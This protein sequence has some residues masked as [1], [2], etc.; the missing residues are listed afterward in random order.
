MSAET[1]KGMTNW[2]VIVLAAGKG[3]RMKSKRPKVLH[4]LCG[5]PMTAHVI[6]AAK[7]A[8]VSRIVV[9]VGTGAEEVRAALGTGYAYAEQLEQKG[10]GHAVLQ[11]RDLLPSLPSDPSPLPLVPGGKAGIGVP[12][13]VLNGDLPLVTEESLRRLMK[14]HEEHGAVMTFLTAHNPDS[15]GLGRI[16]RDASDKA[17]GI[18]EWAQATEAQR[19]GTEI[20]VG[21]YCFD[22]SWLWPALAQV[23]PSTSG[24]VYLTDLVES[25][26]AAGR[27][28]ETVAVVGLAE[29]MGVD[30]RLRLSQAEAVMRQRI[31]EHWMR[32]GVTLVDPQSILI[33][34]GAQIGQDTVIQPQTIVRGA[35]IIGEDCVIGPWTVVADSTIGNGCKVFGSVMEGATLEDHVEVGP[36]SHLRPEAYLERGVHVGN[37]VEIKK[38]RL[39]QDTK[40]GH[41]S[42]IGDATIGRN[43]NIGAGTITCNF[44]GV[45]KLPTTIEDDVFVGCDTMLVAPVRMGARSKTGAGAVVIRDV[46]PDTV[47]VGVPAKPLSKKPEATPRAGGALASGSSPSE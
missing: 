40:S 45:N 28:V 30:T 3:T 25:A 9:V 8:G 38:S 36:F 21:A 47:V 13:L 34:A 6:A 15:E 46:P 32:E 12:I 18:I 43:V 29:A 16:V 39:G 2:T 1:E 37:Y 41:F 4:E 44:D 31:R 20:N 10:T 22:Q 5:Q 14:C 33:D 17:V 26:H 42:Y 35:T 7:A 23:K 24:E 19:R 27:V 11:A